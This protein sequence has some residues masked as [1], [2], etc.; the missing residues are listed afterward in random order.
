VQHPSNEEKEYTFQYDHFPIAFF[1]YVTNIVLL[2]ILFPKHEF[3]KPKSMHNGKESP[4]R[5]IDRS[6]VR[7]T[8]IH[9]G[10]M[11]F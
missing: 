1:G 11:L 10:M 3:E 6:S 2:S 7:E 9:N 5:A 4:T 8:N